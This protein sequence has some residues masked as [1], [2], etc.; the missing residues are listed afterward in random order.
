[1]IVNT[2][3]SVIDF[4]NAS[5][6]LPEPALAESALALGVYS[7]LRISPSIWRC[8]YV[9]LRFMLSY[10]AAGLPESRCSAF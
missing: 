2:R 5:A 1:M 6:D 3:T 4:F 7:R 9:E 8:A 10:S